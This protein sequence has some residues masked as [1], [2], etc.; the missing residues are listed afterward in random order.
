MI[1]LI[2]SNMFVQ[3]GAEKIKSLTARD[4]IILLSFHDDT[5]PISMVKM[6]SSLKA[7]LEIKELPECE[8]EEQNKLIMAYTLGRVAE[9]YK[10]SGKIRIYSENLA[11]I[12]EMPE[13]AAELGLIMDDEVKKAPK[14]PKTS[15]PKAK[16]DPKE[17]KPVEKAQPAVE[18][19]VP[20]KQSTEP[21]SKRGRKKKNFSIV[22]M[23]CERGGE[24]LRPL[25]ESS[26]AGLIAAIKNATDAKIG[27]RTQLQML[28][29]E[30]KGWEDV[31]KILQP[32]FETLKK[33]L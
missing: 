18:E 12:A 22:E 19:K 9:Q 5:M 4:T 11:F 2:E 25:V 30:E 31:L 6:L 13:I 1:Y 3:L 16:A 20:E 26:E 7:N 28:F 17:K 32:E 24:K 27:L 10:Q 15:E 21:S 14:K 29:L 8:S 33:S 23:I